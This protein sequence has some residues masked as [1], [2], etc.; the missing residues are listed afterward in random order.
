MRNLFEK[1]CRYAF[2]NKYFKRTLKS[3]KINCILNLLLMCSFALTSCCFFEDDVLDEDFSY[4]KNDSA[5]TSVIE[6]TTINE[7][8]VVQNSGKNEAITENYEA[9]NSSENITGD[10]VSE[11]TIPSETSYTI[12]DTSLEAIAENTTNVSVEGS[13]Q[14][15]DSEIIENKNIN[16]L[17]IV[18]HPDDE[19]LWGSA[20]LF[21]GGYLVLCLT[22]GYDE[23]RSS[24]FKLNVQL[25]GNESIILDHVDR[26]S[27]GKRDDWK[28]SMESIRADIMHYMSLKHWSFVVTHNPEGEYGHNHHI[29]TNRMVT[30]TFDSLD[31]IDKLFFFGKF[32]TADEID[33]VSD[34]MPELSPIVLEAK[35]YLCSLYLSQYRSVARYSHMFKY[36]NWTEYSKDN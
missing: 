30:E 36:E 27:N 15:T 6:D 35:E 22:N 3:K 12:S 25:T 23:Q 28:S 10:V 8:I 17:M 33:D 5:V 1:N 11:T 19:T 9:L 13:S 14:L 21:D 24:E 2:K 16:K 31:N 26:N 34:Y 20:H 4:I 32:Y 29:L 7:D 18:A